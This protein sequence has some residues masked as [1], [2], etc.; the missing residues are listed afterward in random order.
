MTQRIC[1]RCNGL[2][3]TVS[4]EYGPYLHCVPVVISLRHQ[5]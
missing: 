1:A 2:V 5:E 4:D 3:V